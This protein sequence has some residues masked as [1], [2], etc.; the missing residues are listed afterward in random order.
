MNSNY[1][2]A[3]TNIVEFDNSQFVYNIGITLGFK[4][5]MVVIQSSDPAITFGLVSMTDTGFILNAKCIN[6][7]L[8]AIIKFYYMCTR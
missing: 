3:G 4:P 7:D 2:V 8:T 6:G 5:S 1:I